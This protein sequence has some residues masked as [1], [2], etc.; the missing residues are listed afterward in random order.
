[1]RAIVDFLREIG[2]D[3]IAIES[4][5]KHPHVTFLYGGDFWRQVVASSPTNRDA[6][7]ADANRQIR[8][9][10]GLVEREKRIGHR[11]PKRARQQAPLA[12]PALVSMPQPDWRTGILAHP[13]ATPS[14]ATLLDAAWWRWWRGI[15]DN[16]DRGL[17]PQRSSSDCAAMGWGT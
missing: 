4:G 11:R 13:A 3:K 15:L 12:A 5:G 6:T 10:L 2:A 16:V 7:I 1:M 9:D 17:A 8:R 14:L